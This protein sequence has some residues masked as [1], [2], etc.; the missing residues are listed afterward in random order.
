MD[1]RRIALIVMT[2]AAVCVGHAADLETSLRAAAAAEEPRVID[3]LKALVA[4][5]SGTMD[6]PGLARVADDLQ[7][8]LGALGARVER[9]K[10]EGVK[11]EALIGRFTG[12]GERRLM[13]IAHMD[14]IYAPGTLAREPVRIADGRLYGPGVADSKGGIAVILHSLKLLREAGWKDY[15]QLTVLFNGD[16][17]SQS[18][19][20][21]A[22]IAALGAEHDVVLSYEPTP[23]KSVMQAEA[24]L[25]SAAGTG[26]VE[27]E[28]KGRTSHAGAAPGE[29]RN[30]LVEL[31]HQLSQAD[32]LGA[33]VPGAQVNWT[34]AQAGAVRNQ[35]PD[36]ATATAD[37][38]LTAPDAA[39]RLQQRLD[40]LALQRKVPDTEVHYRVRIG[41]PPFAS[42]DGRSVALAKKAKAIYAELDGRPLI[43]IPGTGAGTDAGYAGS[44]GK[45]S[46]LES[47]GLAGWGYH[48]KDEYIEIDSIVPR[49]YLT[50][51]LLVGLGRGD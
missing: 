7:G 32:D 15:A 1:A 10:L 40:A 6:A 11:G 17:E 12:T 48:A 8:R 39:A 36:L 2:C 19:G 28:V 45:P 35:I 47:L 13:L 29:G 24:V 23:A 21:G 18:A 25:L 38:R 20:S 43:F 16:E 4:L 27:L 5:E 3:T 51:R 41:R 33:E 34:L 30:A 31:V 37:L 22:L 49:V 26:T 46:V 42:P 14:T 44:S 50:T 9:R